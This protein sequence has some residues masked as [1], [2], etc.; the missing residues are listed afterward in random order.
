MATWS[1]DDYRCQ[2]SSWP[3]VARVSP[4]KLDLEIVRNKFAALTKAIN[5]EKDG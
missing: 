3:L 4:T 5:A 2:P 1:F